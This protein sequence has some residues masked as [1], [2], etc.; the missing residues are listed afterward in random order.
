[1]SVKSWGSGRPDYYNTSISSRPQV[2]ENQTKWQLHESYTIGAQGAAIS[3]FYTVPDGYNLSFG[4]GY[5][6]ADNSCINKLRLIAGNESLIGDFRYDVRGDISVSSLTGQVLA[7]NTELIAYL[8]NNDSITSIFS[9]IL[10]GVLE[11][12]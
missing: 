10:T 1:M 3:T 6:T 4:G 12:L 2:V 5:I 11:K 8:W 7:E 9:L